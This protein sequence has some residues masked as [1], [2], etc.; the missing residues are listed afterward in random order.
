MH[1]LEDINL[2]VIEGWQMSL[3]TDVVSK[4]SFS[5]RTDYEHIENAQIKLVYLLQSLYS[6]LTSN[7]NKAFI[8]SKYL[9]CLSSTR[10]SSITICLL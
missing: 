1:S 3:S 10:L 5:A 9:L 2:D 6:N 7:D 8:F 4:R